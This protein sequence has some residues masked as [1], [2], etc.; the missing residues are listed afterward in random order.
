MIRTIKFGVD[1]HSIKERYQ[2]RLDMVVEVLEYN[3]S[4]KVEIAGHTDNTGTPEYNLSLSEKRARSVKSYLVK[5]GIS[6]N[7]LVPVG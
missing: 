4:L 3:R 1:K 6:A 7:R 5:Q 2:P